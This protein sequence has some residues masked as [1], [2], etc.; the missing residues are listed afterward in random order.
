M[1]AK[2]LMCPPTYY[3]FAYEI[4]PWMSVKRNVSLSTAKNQWDFLYKLLTNQLGAKIELVEPVKGLPDMVFT[5]NAGLVSNNTF[6]RSNFRH[7]ERQPEAAFFETWFRD[8]NYT[9]VTL[10][11]VHF[12]EGEGDAFVMG[13]SLICGYHFHADTQAHQIVA[14]SLQ[15][16]LISIK[17]IDERFYRFD[18]CFCPLNDNTALLYQQ[19]IAEEGAQKLKAAI[20]NSIRLKLVDALK[21]ICNSI[22]VGHNLIAP[23][24]CHEPAKILRLLG[25]QIYEVDLSEFAKAGGNAKCMVLT[26]PNED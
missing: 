15:K 16:D 7:K 23:R 17:I 4:N 26:L 12:F 21:L 19:A 10:P 5:A 25:Y 1:S 3:H 14:E 13:N 6:V 22:V 9:V 24:G 8:H 20:K 11:R 2:F 18:T